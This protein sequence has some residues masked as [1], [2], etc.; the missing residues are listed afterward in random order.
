[1]DD[2]LAVA[3]RWLQSPRTLLESAQ[4]SVWM[5][6]SFQALERV[7]VPAPN[8]LWHCG[9]HEGLRPHSRAKAP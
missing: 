5:A 7:A 2:I 1:M 9:P 8:E 3:V 4:E 6:G